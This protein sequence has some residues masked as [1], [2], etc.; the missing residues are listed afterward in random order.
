MNINLKT[1][2]PAL[3]FLVVGF[4]I[5]FLF[6]NARE[7]CEKDQYK[8]INQDL[9]VN[10]FIVRKNSYVSFKHTL[11]IF[12]KEQKKEEKVIDVSVYFRDLKNG[13]TLGINEHTL[14]SPASLLKIPLLLTFYNLKDNYTGLFDREII[15]Q[16]ANGN[17]EQSIKPSVSI[18]VG[19][20]YSIKYL[21]EIMIRQSDN[22]AYYTLLRYLREI[23]P[24]EDLLKNTFVDLGII[25]PKDFLDNTISVKSYGG[26]FVQLYHSSYFTQKKFSEEVLSLLT[27]SEWTKG[28]NAGLPKN[29]EVAHKF[30]ER[31]GFAGDLV[32]LHDCGVVYYPENPY[33]LCVMT[34]GYNIDELAGVIGAISK[35][36]YEEFV[37]RKI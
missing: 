12:I 16:E 17:L 32:Q 37:S 6:F 34:R 18:K 14:F 7:T 33:M 28:L 29:I 4:G 5:S 9:C 3:F 21:L 13:P 26:I 27:K 24:N 22:R 19:Q 20:K 35:M 10:K 2:I 36:F 23:Y 25:D 30:G 1:I 8:Y 11:E 31:F 15:A